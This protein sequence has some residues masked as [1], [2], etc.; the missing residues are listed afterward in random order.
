[1]RREQL[2]ARATTAVCSKRIDVTMV[3]VAKTAYCVDY[4]A[5]LQH[6]C[7]LGVMVSAVMLRMSVPRVV[8]GWWACSRT[9][10]RQNAKANVQ[11]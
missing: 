5:V 10:S 3:P 11:L 2:A 1:M 7:S 6:A 4:G 8:P 9:E